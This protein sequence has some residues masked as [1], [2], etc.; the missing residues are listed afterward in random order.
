M[1]NSNNRMNWTYHFKMNEYKLFS[2]KN[3]YFFV[4]KFKTNLKKKIYKQ[5]K[6]LIK[7]KHFNY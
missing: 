4:K 7:K 1:L 6:I 2:Y 3:K 5:K